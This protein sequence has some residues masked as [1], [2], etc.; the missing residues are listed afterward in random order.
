MSLSL[1][2]YY[3]D[4][5]KKKYFKIEKSHSAPA[6]A[7][8]SAANVKRRKIETQHAAAKHARA[9]KTKRNV[10]RARVLREPLL[11]GFLD[12][13]LG[14]GALDADLSAAAVKRSISPQQYRTDT[15]SI[16]REPSDCNQVSSISYHRPSHRMLVTSREPCPDPG[17]YFFSPRVTSP[18]EDKPNWELGAEPPATQYNSVHLMPG[19]RDYSVN[20]AI[21]APTASPDLIC[22]LATDDGIIRLTSNDD[23]GWIT[24]RSDTS[25]QRS[26]RMDVLA[27]TFH[28][29]NPSV[30]YAG[31]RSSAV[32][33]LDLRAP[34]QSWKSFQTASAVTHLRS[35]E[36]NPNHLLV[37]A[38]RSTLHI[39]DL[40]FLTTQSDTQPK[41]HAPL[42]RKRNHNHNY[43][44]TLPSAAHVAP[45][46]ATPVLT[47]PEYRNEAHI[48]IGFDVN[49]D[50]G[51]V[52]AAHDTDDGRVAIYSLR[53]GLRLRAPA[54]DSASPKGPVKSLMFQSMPRDRHAS[55]WIG[56]AGVVKKFSVGVT[57]EDD[58]A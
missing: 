15:S 23:I 9:E 37:A 54:V 48:H 30:L 58:E 36:S 8:W 6:S 2:G 45:H 44:R 28:A 24:P 19:R 31:T 47:F 38:L 35:L 56:H 17:V 29:T 7:A 14:I 42:P 10:K 34:S 27:Q 21:P 46:V 25:H 26:P 39:Y 11:G 3:Y 33:T 22:T 4:E 40:R 50:A 55:L 53:S 5:V 57:K 43:G 20:L 49:Y 12:R 52:A 1:P 41:L 13:Q 16:F 32:K 51:I 18:L